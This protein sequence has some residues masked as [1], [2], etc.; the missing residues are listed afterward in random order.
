[1]AGSTII[2]LSPL[3]TLRFDDD[4]LTIVRLWRPRR[5]P[6][7][8]VAGLVYTRVH[9]NHRGPIPFQLRL[10]LADGAPEPGRFLSEGRPPAPYAT[11]PVLFRTHN[12]DLGRSSPAQKRIYAELESRGFERPEPSAMRYQPRGY[13]REEQTLAVSMDLRREHHNTHPV[14]VN[15][16]G[17]DGRLVDDVLPALAERHH[18]AE[19]SQV[20]P[21]YTIFFFE[22]PDAGANSAAFIAEARRVVPSGWRVT[23]SALPEPRRP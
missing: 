1:M 22:G 17:S 23:A 7:D 16:D 8:D 19:T 21:R 12:L 3:T 5:I 4:A 2:R 18:A 13:T 6:W 20:R 11:G 9:T 10:V 15:H 14:T